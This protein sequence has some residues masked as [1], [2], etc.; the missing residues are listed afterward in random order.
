MSLVLKNLISFRVIGVVE[1]NHSRVNHYDK[2]K[3]RCSRKCEKNIRRED[4]ERKVLIRILVNVLEQM[5]YKQKLSQVI[6]RM[7]KLSGSGT[8]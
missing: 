3:Y 4:E 5:Q 8:N 7:L 6:K 1:E 2:D